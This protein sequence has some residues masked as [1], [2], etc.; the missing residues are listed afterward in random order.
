VLPEVDAQLD[1]DDLDQ[2]RSLPNI[3]AVQYLHFPALQ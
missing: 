2:L 1:N 3:N